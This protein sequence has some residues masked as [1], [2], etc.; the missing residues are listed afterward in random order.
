[1]L[2]TG[3]LEMILA[4]LPIFRFRKWRPSEWAQVAQTSQCSLRVSA[5]LFSW[6]GLSGCCLSQ[7]T[8]QDTG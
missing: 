7:H 3:T 6:S 5:G 2:D 1:M 8:P 4:F